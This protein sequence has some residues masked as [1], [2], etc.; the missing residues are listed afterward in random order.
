MASAK[1]A[2]SIPSLPARSAIVR[3]SFRLQRTLQES[4]VGTGAHVEL[5]HGRPEQALA[6]IV[7]PAVVAHLRRPH[8]SVG[9]Q[10]T[11]PLEAPAL[12]RARHLHPRLDGSGWFAQT[13]VGQLFVFHARHVDVDVVRSKIGAVQQGAGDAADPPGVGLVAAHHG[14][15][16]GALM[17]MVTVQKPGS[18][19]PH[20][21]CCQVRPE[22]NA[23]EQPR[24]GTP[25][26]RRPGSLSD[27]SSPVCTK[28]S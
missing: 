24:P 26:A 19:C 11:A 18:P 22:A 13:F 1:C 7:H 10:S 21:L 3:A 28:A 27:P 20:V 9:Q 15:G 16:A 4:V 23:T 14:M 12:A 17:D 25:K 8:I 6:G 2:V 5:L